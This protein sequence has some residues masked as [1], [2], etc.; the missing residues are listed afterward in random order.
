[1]NV[2]RLVNSIVNNI[3]NNLT[4]FLCI[5]LLNIIIVINSSLKIIDQRLLILQ[6]YISYNLK[7]CFI[8]SVN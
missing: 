1:M 7:V 4:F 2:A 3:K 5:G 8:M 6:S